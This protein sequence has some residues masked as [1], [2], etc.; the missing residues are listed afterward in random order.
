MPVSQS[1]V[2]AGCGQVGS[3][4]GVRLAQLGW[5]VYGMRRFVAKL[6]PLIQPLAA[7]LSDKRCP[8]HWPIA[9]PDYVVYCA[10]ADQH[11]EAAYRHAY[12]MGVQHL[13]SWLVQ[14]GQQPKRLLF[15]SSTSVYGQQT[16]E[17]V[18]ELSPM[19]P[20]GF[21]GQ[22]LCEAEAQLWRC[23]YP[24]SV[25][26]LAGI[27]GPGRDH[28]LRQVRQGGW[29][30]NRSPLYSNRIHTDDAAGLLAFLLQADAQGVPLADCYIGVDNEPAA[31]Q[32]VIGWLQQQLNVIPS[33]VPLTRRTGS[34]RCHNG[35]ARALGWIPQYPSYREGYMG[36]LRDNPVV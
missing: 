12:I 34:K 3:Q 25:V 35:R 1:V 15:V 31:L 4:L 13:L 16:G 32:N 7:D 18:D 21:A 29:L 20:L 22:I 10:A 24:V 28:L 17:W 6:P 9:T 33:G 14:R 36:L 11:T 23:T 30:A 8:N 26:R 19:Q 5:F 27:Y 2:I